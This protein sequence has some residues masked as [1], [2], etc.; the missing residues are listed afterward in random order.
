MKSSKSLLC[1]AASSISSLSAAI[2][3]I[4]ETKQQRAL[5][6]ASFYSDLYSSIRNVSK[7]IRKRGFACYVVGNRTVNSILLP[8][9]TA[10]RDFFE[11][12]GFEYVSTPIREIPNKRMPSR[13]SPSNIT[14]E[15]SNT[16]LNEHIVIMRKVMN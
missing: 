8:T 5:E 4:Y 7:I 15:T 9:S 10:I 13:N 1:L 12:T 3:L 2:Q 14:G 16:M 11:S 6:V